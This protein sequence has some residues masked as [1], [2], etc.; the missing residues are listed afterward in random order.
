MSHKF[1][2]E[3]K[4]AGY[5]RLSS[6]KQNSTDADLDAARPLRVFCAFSHQAADTLSLMLQVTRWGL[7]EFD[8]FSHHTLHMLDQ[9]DQ[10]EHFVML[11]N[12]YY[13]TNTL[14]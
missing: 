12:L 3:K 7:Y 1:G 2:K 4:T 5:Y 6:W 10:T 11:L 13:G 14:P 9:T 8:L